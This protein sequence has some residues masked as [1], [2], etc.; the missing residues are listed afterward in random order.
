MTGRILARLKVKVAGA[1]VYALLW[2]ASKESGQV[3][4]A[5]TASDPAFILAQGRHCPHLYYYYYYYYYYYVFCSVF[6]S[7]L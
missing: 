6:Q 7:V 1:C 3:D 4:E 2:S 5:I